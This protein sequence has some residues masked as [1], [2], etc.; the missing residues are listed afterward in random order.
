MQY[1]TTGYAGT[2][3]FRLLYTYL[4]HYTSHV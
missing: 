2:N 1:H 4:N 3:C